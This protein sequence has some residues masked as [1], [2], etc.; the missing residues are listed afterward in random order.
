MDDECDDVDINNNDDED[1]CEDSPVAL[2]EAP[3]LL[4][5]AFLFTSNT[6]LTPPYFFKMA[7]NDDI[8]T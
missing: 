1:D 4:V 2:A 5:T 3:E 7:I 6:A 8:A